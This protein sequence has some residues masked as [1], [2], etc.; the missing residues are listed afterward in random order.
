MKKNV[1]K[2]FTFDIIISVT[3]CVHVG[4]SICKLYE[5]NH[6]SLRLRVRI[7][8]TT[9][10]YHNTYREIPLNLWDS[11]NPIGSRL[12][13]SIKVCGKK[14][15]LSQWNIW[16]Q[17]LFPWCHQLLAETKLT[18]VIYRLLYDEIWGKNYRRA[19]VFASASLPYT[20]IPTPVTGFLMKL[21]RD[22]SILHT[23]PS[24]GW[25]Q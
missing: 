24:L 13:Y 18:D 6:Y 4:V 15:S 3:C 8:H 21:Q 17:S 25:S 14:T 9:I 5:V 10:W 22:P 2:L 16:E 7:F 11:H 20:I 12:S 19:A 23:S 1:W